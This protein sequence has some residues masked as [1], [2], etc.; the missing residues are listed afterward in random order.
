M[1]LADSV[2][3]D[4]HVQGTSGAAVTLVQYGDYECPYTRLSRY[5]VRQLQRE[6]PDTLRFV[7]R[8]F[9]LEQIHPHSRPAALAAEASG[10]QTDFWTMHEY[11]FEHQNH[12]EELDLQKYA[13]ELGLDADRFERDRRSPEIARRIDQD[14][15]SGERSGVEGTPTFYVNDIRHDGGYDLESL[16]QAIV[17][18]MQRI[19]KAR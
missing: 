10:A 7:F 3:S 11:L 19:S 2:V 5:A 8:H 17:T 9:P 12:L 14:I 16:R 13:T 18:S 4:D 15:N 6:Y 1:R